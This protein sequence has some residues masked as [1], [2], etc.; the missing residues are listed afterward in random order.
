MWRLEARRRASFR[1]IWQILNDRD[2]DKRVDIPDPL[3][4]GAA[5]L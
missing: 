5:T 3:E 2:G 1:R 4:I